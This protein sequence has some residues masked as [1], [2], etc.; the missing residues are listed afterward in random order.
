M[1]KKDQDSLEYYEECLD[2]LSCTYTDMC[3]HN[4]KLEAYIKLLQHLLDYSEISYPPF[5]KP[6]KL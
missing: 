6:I 5:E 1:T 3:N 2:Q 4:K